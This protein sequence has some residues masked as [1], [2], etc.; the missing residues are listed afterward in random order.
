MLRF[1]AVPSKRNIRLTRDVLT[2]LLRQFLVRDNPVHFLK[3]GI[4]DALPDAQV[5]Y[6]HP[7]SIVRPTLS[8]C[9]RDEK[10]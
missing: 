9:C 6:A 5:V 8:G 1:A 3:D 7:V 10:K 2:R 4:G